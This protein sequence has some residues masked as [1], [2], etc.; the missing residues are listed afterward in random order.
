M[1]KPLPLQALPGIAT[2]RPPGGRRRTGPRITALMR[3]YDGQVPGAS[4][5]VL[6]VGQTVFRRSYRLAVL[7][8]GTRQ[9]R[10]ATSG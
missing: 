9:R 3:R 7:E 1:L 4:V 2:E 6:K 5:R 10:P 8:D